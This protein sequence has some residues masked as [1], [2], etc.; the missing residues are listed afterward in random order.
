MKVNFTSKQ[1]AISG[2]LTALSVVFFFLSYYLK[3]A[4]LAFN[5]ILSVI[6][7]TGFAAG[8]FGVS[9]LIYVATSVL[10]VVFTDV[11]NALPYI[12]FF[13]L[14]PIISRVC[15]QFIKNSVLSTIIRVAYCAVCV[16]TVYLLCDVIANE[17]LKEVL[18]KGVIYEVAFCAVGGAVLFLYERCLNYIYPA[19]EKRIKRI[20]AKK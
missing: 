1:I 17:A 14:V 16:V 5:A 20:T 12:V 10:G 15:V 19:L 9:I 3:M 6:V 13:G 18:Q 7:L 4:T 2:I 8:G 11:F